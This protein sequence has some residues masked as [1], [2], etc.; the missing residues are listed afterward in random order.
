MKEECVETSGHHGLGM[1]RTGESH[2]M[3]TIS[4]VEYTVPEGF[5]PR[6]QV[7]RCRKPSKKYEDIVLLEVARGLKN[8]KL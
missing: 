3:E 7:S 5:N 6:L 4:E 1:L 8:I 2:P